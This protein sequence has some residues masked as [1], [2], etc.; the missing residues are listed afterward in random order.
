MTDKDEGS[1]GMN[2]KDRIGNS[3]FWVVMFTTT[4]RMTNE[5]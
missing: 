2:W 1:T 4:P 5:R 3:A